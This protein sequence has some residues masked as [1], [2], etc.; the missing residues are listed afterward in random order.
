[1]MKKFSLLI[2][3]SVLAVSMHAAPAYKADTKVGVGQFKSKISCLAMG[4][5]RVYA[6]ES[7]GAVHAFN[8]ASGEREI[9]FE[10]GLE[11]T[12]AI[13]VD[14]AGRIFVLATMVEKKEITRGNRKRTI[15]MPIGV[16]C[17]VFDRDGST[18]K[19]LKLDALKSAKA[20]SFVG[21]KLVVADIRQRALVFL[22]PETGKKSGGLNKGLR[23]CCGIFDFCVG[24]DNTVA[25][26]NLGAF[27][28]QQYDLDGQLVKAFG[29][30]GKELDDF[31]GCCNPV[32]AGYLADG[33]IVTVEKDPTRIKVYN[34]EGKDA[35]L[36]DGVEELV[37]G[38]SHIPVA[39][40]AA[41]NIFLAAG[42]KGYIVKCIPK[43]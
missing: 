42:R 23:L 39:I 30:R 27:Q 31:Q 41:G 16:Q 28:V 24:P 18:L 19:E 36:I 25:V 35:Q 20:A 9:H 38:C 17:K 11:S 3:L 10:T 15:D 40:D 2:A 1:M 26:S 4:G 8:V 29:K 33:S 37:K 21:D 12:G 6:L 14:A 22:D 13:A 7:S 5:D 43:S 34:A 32:S